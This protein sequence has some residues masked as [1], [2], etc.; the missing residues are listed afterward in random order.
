ME[1][2]YNRYGIQCVFH[3]VLI[4]MYM[5]S[6]IYRGRSTDTFDMVIMSSNMVIALFYY[7][8]FAFKF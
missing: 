5:S 1:K 7:M 8:R 3:T 2:D 4:T 6:I